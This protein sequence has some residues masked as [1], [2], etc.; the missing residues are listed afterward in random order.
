[1]HDKIKID[2]NTGLMIDVVSPSE[3]GKDIIE[4]PCPDGFH[5]PKWDGEKWVEGGQAPSETSHEPSESER[6][7]AIEAALLDIILGG[8]S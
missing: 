6:L 2:L 3:S 5:F 1:M 7:A 8:M 4:T